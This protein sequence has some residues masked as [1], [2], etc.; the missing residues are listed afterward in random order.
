MENDRVAFDL[1]ANTICDRPIAIEKISESLLE[2]LWNISQ[3]HDLSHIVAKC[4]DNLE[5]STNSS[6]LQK[7]K[8]MQ[9]LAV[10]RYIQ[11]EYEL[12][13]LIDIFERECID[14]IPLKGSV[15]RNYYPEAWLRTSCD[16]DILVKN[17]DLDKTVDLL[18]EKL[19]EMQSVFLPM[20]DNGRK[21][22]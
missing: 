16:I 21:Y 5:C 11:L 3:K 7:F 19:T 17:E 4:I 14:F 15:L 2:T 6:T 8:K 1:I 9:T 10:Y 20:N 18:V 12:N 13:S 22:F